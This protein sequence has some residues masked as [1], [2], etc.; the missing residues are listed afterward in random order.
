MAGIFD[1]FKR[2]NANPNRKGAFYLDAD[3]AKTFGDIDYMRK[4]KTV[5]RTFAKTV[6]GGGGELIQEVS[7]MKAKK[8]TGNETYNQ[9]TTSN[10][11]STSF[12]STSTTTNNSSVS[13]TPTRSSG[14][15]NTSMDMFRNMA[16]NIKK[17]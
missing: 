11:S 3:E 12:N 4:P 8:R 5:K 9:T 17:R 7:A 16:K 14:K 15:T 6:S 1:I 13:S 2:K 10:S